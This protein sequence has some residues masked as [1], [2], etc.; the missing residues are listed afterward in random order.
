MIRKKKYLNCI[1]YKIKNKN[2][3]EE[4]PFLPVRLFKEF[5]FLSIK[6]KDIFKT[7]F[8][9]GTTSGNLSKIYLISP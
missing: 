8:S 2:N 9:S 3:I 1:N 4:I 6:K 7:L 5:D